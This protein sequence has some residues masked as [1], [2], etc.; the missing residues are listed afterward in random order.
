MGKEEESTR[1]AALLSRLPNPKDILRIDDV[2][3]NWYYSKKENRDKE[4]KLLVQVRPLER[5]PIKIFEEKQVPEKLPKS[6]LQEKGI[7][8]GSYTPRPT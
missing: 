6:Q 2:I 8:G 4:A 3:I 7:W 5:L 1:L